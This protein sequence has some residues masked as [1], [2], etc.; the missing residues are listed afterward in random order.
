MPHSMTS[1]HSHLC[2]FQ[3]V[4]SLSS[5]TDILHKSFWDSSG[6]FKTSQEPSK[7]S[8]EFLNSP[9]WIW[10]IQGW[11]TNT[12]LNT[13][14]QYICHIRWL[15]N[16]F[17]VVHLNYY[18]GL[19]IPYFSWLISPINY[20]QHNYHHIRCGFSQY[21]NQY[22]QQSMNLSQSMSYCSTCNILSLQYDTKL[23]YSIFHICDVQDC[24]Q[25]TLCLTMS[26]S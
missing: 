2:P 25:A 6:L 18:L 24:L 17:S 5:C 12:D 8:Q 26:E 9:Q 21:V 11:I 13:T 7:P 22:L 19:I 1:N 23:E 14:Q 15:S 20:C 4:Q 3:N 16:I 10:M